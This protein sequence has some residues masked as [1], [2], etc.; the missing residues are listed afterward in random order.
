MSAK[1]E[2]LDWRKQSAVGC[3]FAR[4]MATRPNGFGQRIEVI[5]AR[6]N[7]VRVAASIAKRV[8]L[9]LAD[10]KASIATL[11]LP[12][13]TTLAKLASVALELRAHPHWHVTTTALRG[14]PIANLVAVHVTRDI[15]FENTACPSEALMMGPFQEFPPTRRAPITA[16]ELF[17]GPPLPRD[18]KT[19]KPT[20][21]ANL[22]HAD[23]T[24][25][26]LDSAQIDVMW[27]S[28]RVARLKSLGGRE[29]DR[30]KAKVSFVIPAVL[31]RRL[32]C[33]P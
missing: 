24:D 4:L 14:A 19:H 21:K 16:L 20:T 18:P 5:S 29:D 2:Y 7:P 32:G 30:A 28:S 1:S 33:E 25:T 12:D 8:D 15:P 10:K 13:I 22:A 17:V 11:L 3:V 27:E 6:G 26:E 31:A 9:L 23:L